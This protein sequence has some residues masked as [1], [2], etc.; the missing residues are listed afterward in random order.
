MEGEGE[1]GTRKV[2]V[3]SG[4]VGFGEEEEDTGLHEVGWGENRGDNMKRFDCEDREKK[5]RERNEWYGREGI[6]RGV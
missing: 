4:E 3:M 1:G 6:V 5:T 2:R